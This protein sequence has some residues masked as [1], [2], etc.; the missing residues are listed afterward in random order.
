M[1]FGACFKVV[2]IRGGVELKLR[3]LEIIHYVRVLHE[4][5]KLK[6]LTVGTGWSKNHFY[7][8]LRSFE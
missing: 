8:I 4:D 3:G 6:K 5:G 2:V 1:S 7:V